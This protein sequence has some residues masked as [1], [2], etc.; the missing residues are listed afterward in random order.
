MKRWDLYWANVPYEDDP[1]QSKTR[2][3][4]IANDL[5]VYVLV[6]RVTTHAAREC[7]RFDYPLLYWDYAGLKRPSVVRISK[8][9]KLRPEEIGDYI[10]SLRSADI[11]EIQ[12]RMMLYK[13]HLQQ[14][15]NGEDKHNS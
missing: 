7:D 5:C 3:V 6:L 4:I 13:Q 1:E 12:H 2:P 15:R 14:K 8:L 10:G 9:A 11:Q